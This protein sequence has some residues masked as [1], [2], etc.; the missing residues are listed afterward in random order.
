MDV[1]IEQQ[2]HKPI[3]LGLNRIISTGIYRQ[4]RK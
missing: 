3:Q 1:I 4:L 2:V